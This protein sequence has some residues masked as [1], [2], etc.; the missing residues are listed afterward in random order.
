MKWVEL[1]VCGCV[2]CV[3]V[4]NE[5]K[6]SMIVTENNVSSSM[7]RLI[8]LMQIQCKYL[9]IFY[10]SYENMKKYFKYVEYM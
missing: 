4:F 6:N 8:I 10:N 9:Y 5:K 7:S 1:L 3:C 2:W